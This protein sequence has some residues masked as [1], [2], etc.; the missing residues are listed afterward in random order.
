MVKVFGL[1]KK[2]AGEMVRHGNH[3]WYSSCV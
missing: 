3:T 1:E 2:H